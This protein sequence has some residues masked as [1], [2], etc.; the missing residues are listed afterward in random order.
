MKRVVP[1]KDP[2]EDIN[3]AKDMKEDDLV[4][5]ISISDLSESSLQVICL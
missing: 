3:V 2:L 1:E 5:N 4:R